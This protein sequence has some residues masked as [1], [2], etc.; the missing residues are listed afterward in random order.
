MFFRPWTLILCPDPFTVCGEEVGV[1][2]LLASHMEATAGSS[3][4][5]SSMREGSVEGSFIGGGE[6]ALGRC[7]RGALGHGEVGILKGGGRRLR[8][9][10]AGNFRGRSRRGSWAV[11]GTRGGARGWTWGGTGGGEWGGIWGK[12][13]IL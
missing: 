2:F 8:G 1:L 12:G 10:G 3:S 4:T 9:L 7:G 13:E 5:L 11:V 6:D